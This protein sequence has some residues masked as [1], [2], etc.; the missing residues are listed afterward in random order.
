MQ[1]CDSMKV[2]ND[3]R[4]EKVRK[5]RV[6]ER[7]LASRPA[8]APCKVDKYSHVS[9]KLDVYST[10]ASKRYAEEADDMRAQLIIVNRKKL[11]I[12]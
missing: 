4:R 2:E 5:L 10:P 8:G 6:I 11:Q 12:E 3:D 1:E 9:G 7:G